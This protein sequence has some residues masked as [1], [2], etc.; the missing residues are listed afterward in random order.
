MPIVYSNL[1]GRTIGEANS[2]GGM[3]FRMVVYTVSEL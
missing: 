1:A 2:S 3:R